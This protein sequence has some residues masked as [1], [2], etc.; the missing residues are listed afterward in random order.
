MST[1]R[2][3]LC[4]V[5]PAHWKALMGGA[6]YQIA[7]L[8]D[9]LATLDRYEIDY[10]AYHVAPD[11][12]PEGYRIVRIGN[13]GD[14]PRWG[15]ITHALPLYRA[16]R[17]IQPDVIYQRVGGGYTA[18]A[19]YF[20]RRHGAR[21]IWHVAHDADLI[22]NATLAGRNP[23]RRYLERRSIEYGLRRAHHIVVQTDRQAALLRENYQRT[24]DVVLANFHPQPREAIDKSGPLRVLWVAN[25]KPWKQPDAFVRLA[26]ALSDLKEVRFVMIG[27]EA[28]GAGHEAVMRDIRSAANIDY[29]G[30]LSQSAV[31]E[32]LASAHVFVN[33]SLHE[34]FPNTFI[35]AW[36]REV[37]VVSLHVNPDG[38]FDRE[39]I[40]IHAGTEERLAQAVRMLVTDPV[41]R[42]EYALRA[43]SH[44]TLQHSLR[45]VDVL[46]K[47]ID[48]CVRG[49]PGL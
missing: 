10:L 46:V 21:L 33:T 22:P 14:A 47:L 9:A 37:P 15:Y 7:C 35:Q 34:G 36:M 27:A 5:T 26:T 24:A 39:A 11:F 29:L 4:I 49:R 2:T 25:L 1:G 30:A 17:E 19:A 23:I 6:E 42:A 43:R 41:T 32:L 3:R 12:H 8:L 38:V 48:A 18:I 16:L 13:G 40:G 31:N 28:G 20:A 44:A 45:N